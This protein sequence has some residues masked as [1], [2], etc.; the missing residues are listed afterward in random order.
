MEDRFKL[1]KYLILCVLL[2]SMLGHLCYVALYV[3]PPFLTY[4]VIVIFLFTK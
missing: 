2:L 1:P 4:E 3:V